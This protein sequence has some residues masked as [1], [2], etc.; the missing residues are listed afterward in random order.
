YLW[1]PIPRRYTSSMQFTTELLEATGIVV[2]PGS[3][4]GQAGEGFVRIA[5]CADE[6]R[7]REA[8]ERMA[9][10]GFGWGPRDHERYRGRR[11]HH[12]DRGCAASHRG[13]RARPRGRGVVAR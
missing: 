4:F 6:A 10:A 8:A 13:A 9:R 1:V 5:L 3:G 11:R 12:V 7:C 2:A